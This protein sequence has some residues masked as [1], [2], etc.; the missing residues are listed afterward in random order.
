MHMQ[1]NSIAVSNDTTSRPITWEA[2]HATA[3]AR[4]AMCLIRLRNPDTVQAG[5][6]AAAIM[7]CQ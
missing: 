6:P 3:P 5:I 7:H 1:N 2:E 4:K